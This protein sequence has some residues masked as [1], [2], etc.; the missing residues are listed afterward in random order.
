MFAV[1]TRNIEAIRSFEQADNYFNSTRYPARSKKWQEHQRPLRN[2]QS[3]H[4]RI[5]KGVYNNG[6]NQLQYYDLVLYRTP[7]VRYFEPSA[8][9]EHAIWVVNHYTQSSQAFLWN[10]GWYNRKKVTTTEGKEIELQISSQTGISNLLWAD[11]FTCKL[12]FNHEG[13]L[14][15]N[16]SVHVPFARRSST[17]THRGKRNRLRQHFAMIY[18]ML[19]MQYQSF[20]SDIE[21]DSGYG[22][23]FT[24]RANISLAYDITQK[25]H[26]GLVDEITPD[27]M[28]TIMTFAT[29]TCHKIAESIVNRRAYNYEHGAD[30][31]EKL[32]H[33]KDEFAVPVDGERLDDHTQEVRDRLTPSWEDIKRALDLEFQGIARLDKGD[34]FLPFP[35]FAETYPRSC[36]SLRATSQNDLLNLLGVTT[37]NKLIARKGVIY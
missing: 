2:T 35:Q 15:V 7:L 31:W 26:H 1:N 6:E 20:I 37:Y 32:R 27:E 34:Q 30:T 18:D 29:R 36:Y 9:G 8:S 22:K 13:K 33:M 21:V 11:N 4:L 3:P 12:V 16:K 10:A 23:P 14:D 25:L 28:T 5:E 24:G 19:E 17:A